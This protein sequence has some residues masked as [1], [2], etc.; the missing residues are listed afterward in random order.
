VHPDDLQRC[1]TGMAASIQSDL[2]SLGL[3]LFEMFTGK[4]P[5]GRTSSIPKLVDARQR[6]SFLTPSALVGDLDP[7][8]DRIISKCLDPEPHTLSLRARPTPALGRK[9]HAV[10]SL[11]QHTVEMQQSGRLQN[12]GGTENACPAHEKGTQAGDDPI[13]GM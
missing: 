12:D 3:A 9:Q 10:L 2:Y 5:F 8:I 1:L 7:A 11:L 4:R 13:G 6:G